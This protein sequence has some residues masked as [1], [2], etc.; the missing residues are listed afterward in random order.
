MKHISRYMLERPQT[1]TMC[2]WTFRLLA[3]HQDVLAKLREEIAAGCG[4][5]KDAGPPSREN[6]KQ[7]T[8]IHLVIKEGVSPN[9]RPRS[10][11]QEHESSRCRLTR[12]IL[13]VTS[14]PIRPSQL[15]R[16]RPHDDPPF[17]WR[18]GWDGAD[19]RP[20]GRG[21][22]LLR[23]RHAPSKGHLRRRCGGFPARTVG[24]RCLEEHWLGLSAVQW[25]TTFVPRA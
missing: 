11:L 18:S 15:P 22:W 1:L 8:Y 7:L 14:L 13:S 5:G 20:P 6:L 12:W 21:C 4:L 16:G 10:E 19:P 25:W 3:R 17:R 24:G 23:I 9:C 2:K